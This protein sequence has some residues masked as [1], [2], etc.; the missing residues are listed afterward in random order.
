MKSLLYL[1]AL[2][3]FFCL[4]GPGNRVVTGMNMYLKNRAMPDSVIRTGQNVSILFWN[5]ENLYDPFDDS[6]KVDE[7]FTPAGEYHWTWSRFRIK[8]NML[9]K[10]ILAS[11]HG[12][13]PALIGLCE[14]ENRFVLRRLTADTPLKNWQ[15]RV[16]HYDSPDARGVD[17]GLLYLPTRFTPLHSEA[18]AVRFPQDTAARTRDILYVKG[19]PWCGDTLHL[20]VNHWPSR[21]GGEKASRHR[22]ARAAFLLRLKTDSIME[23]DPRASIVIMGD[24]NDEPGDGS[25]SL[26]LGAVAPGQPGR[27]INLM[28]PKC[29]REGTHKFQAHWGILDQFIVS[30]SM[31]GEPA[32]LRTTTEN[33]TILKLPF[34]MIRDERH[35]GSKPFR[36]YLGPRYTGGF[37]D[38]LPVKLELECRE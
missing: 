10:T 6:L 37:S 2:F 19:L 38:H 27:L 11:R 5:V 16:I 23:S 25:L 21:R 32:L 18:I 9:A 17:V 14:I 15:Y 7:A 34:L 26:V 3:L 13:P 33:A 4:A 1:S 8:L 20:F 35:M 29:G 24:F 30:G 31:L 28:I 36:T 12:E 22:R